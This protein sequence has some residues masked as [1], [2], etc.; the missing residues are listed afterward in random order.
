MQMLTIIRDFSDLY[1]F[2]W[3]RFLP[4]Y[5]VLLTKGDGS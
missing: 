2:Y 4:Q 3:W 1:S 5:Q